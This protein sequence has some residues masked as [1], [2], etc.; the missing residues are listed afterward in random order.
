[1]IQLRVDSHEKVPQPPRTVFQG[2]S[3]GTQNFIYDFNQSQLDKIEFSGV[4]GVTSF[5]NLD[6]QQ[7]VS[8]TVITAGADQVTLVNYDDTAHP[9]TASDFLFA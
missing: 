4:T 3:V 8:N 7:S 1:M 5:T 9:L 2:D 6:I